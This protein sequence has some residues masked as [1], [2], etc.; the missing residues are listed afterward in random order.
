MRL[1]RHLVRAA[2]RARPHTPH[3]LLR[4]ALTVASFLPSVT[5]LVA[6]PA[7][8]RVLVVA[9]HPDDE[10]IGVG[11]T[12]ARLARGGATVQVVVVTDG[13]GSIG[14]PYSPTETA[15]R[16]R[17]EVTAAC[18]LLGAQPPQFLH[19]PDGRVA[20]HLDDLACRLQEALRA[21]GPEV[22]FAPT[23]LERHADHRAC[24][25]ALARLPATDAELW[26]YEAH[27]PIPLPDRIVDIRD[28]L[29]TKQA[30]L[31]AHVTAAFAFDLE[32]SLGL[33]RWR[34]LSTDAG[35]GAAEAF[36]TLPWS[37]LPSLSDAAA[38]A[39]DIGSRPA[40]PN[41]A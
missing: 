19:L 26:G 25:A 35:R 6:L 17:A 9:P 21:H 30:A 11:G 32:A 2:A 33:A 41:E 24:T 38:R 31:A 29:P 8:R 18:R 23:P 1:P 36:L 16:R 5:P 37:E 27:T 10:S 34:S 20:E 28:D 4:L 22:V 40:P 7:F 39:W 14:S 13:E 15:R 12:I 3:E